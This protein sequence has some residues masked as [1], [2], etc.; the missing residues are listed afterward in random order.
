VPP[1]GPL[2]TRSGC[3]NGGEGVPLTGPVA[4]GFGL[5]P[6]VSGVC[7]LGRSQ[8]SVGGVGSCGVVV[9]APVLD[10]HAGLEERVELPEV[11]QLVAE[12]AVER[13]GPAVL[14]G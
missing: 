6:E 2:T 13:L 7:E 9:N 1:S 11:E 8:V 12:S 3:E 14:P 10:D 5:V 4:C